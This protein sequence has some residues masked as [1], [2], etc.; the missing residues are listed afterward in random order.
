M[1]AFEAFPGRRPLYML[2]GLGRELRLMGT[3]GAPWLTGFVLCAA[4]GITACDAGPEASPD[5]PL[6]TVPEWQLEEVFRLG[7]LERPDEETFASEP[8]LAVDGEELLYVLHRDRGEIAVFDTAGM[9]VRWIHGGRG[10]GPGEF[11]FPARMGFVGDTLWVRNRTPPRISRFL[12]DGTHVGTERVQVDAGYR[13]TAGVQGVSGYLADGRAWM[14]P[15]GFVMALGEDDP[16]APFVLG[17]RQMEDRTTL[18]S[19]RGQRGRLAGTSFVP[20]PEPPFHAV[21]PDGSEI[22]LVEWSEA[23]PEELSIRL[24]SP[25]G[26]DLGSWTLAVPPAP[27][28]PRVLDSLVQE[29][30][31]RVRDVRERVI[32]RGIPEAQAPSVPSVDEV[33]A[34]AYLPDYFP[35]IRDVRLGLDG[36]VWLQRSQGLTL[37]AW[38]ALDREG[39]PLFQVRLPEGVR[40]R[41]ASRE[42][43]WGTVSDDLGVPYVIRWNLVA[44]DADSGDDA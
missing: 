25:D 29:G 19:W 15:D 35:P 8:R 28:P 22:L 30:R 39:T 2:A 11:R 12:R 18:F 20:V 40:L 26:V 7:G 38:V 24:I 37:G 44:P 1:Y 17:D 14:E 13:T 27:A 31:D 34:R 32:Q 41:Q 3:G 5:D 16:E 6:G 9:L 33:R 42:A 43:L 10:E 4:F 21:A 23:R 36:T